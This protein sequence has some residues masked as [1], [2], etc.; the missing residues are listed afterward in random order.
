MDAK[1]AGDFSGWIGQSESTEDI[2]TLRMARSLLAT[3]DST[4]NLRAGEPAPQ[5]IHWCLAV[6]LAQLSALG[7]DGHPRAGRFHPADAFPR[8]MWASSTVE[9][10][11]PIRIGARIERQATVAAVAEKAG[12]S[13][14][15][16]LVDIDHV[17]R[18][19]DAEAVRERQTI[20]YRE[21]ASAAA[22]AMREPVVE[23]AWNWQRDLAPSE[24]M[25]F[26]YSALTFNGHRIHYDHPYATETEGYQGLVVQ[27]PLIATLLVDL[28][29]RNLGPDALA[30]FSFR[31]VAPAFVG[32]TL[33]LRGRRDGSA[34]HL[35]A[36]GPSGL[37][38]S[39]QARI[40][41][42]L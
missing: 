6:P 30:T 34:L 40:R 37:V 3:L 28:C 17:V 32:A 23:A 25:L 41:E 7:R 29:A 15:L 19:D 13:G 16:L 14:K 2:L 39:A 12:A 26:R 35:A 5:S 4:A 8:R 36:F 21:P 1:V 22:P 9:F 38:M 10:A 27:G 20:V 33:A 24:L 31:A 18:A 42:G 11:A